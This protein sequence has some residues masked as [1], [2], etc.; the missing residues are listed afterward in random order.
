[1][2]SPSISCLGNQRSSARC[3]MQAVGAKQPG[4]PPM[5]DA[6]LSTPKAKQAHESPNGEASW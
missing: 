4:E 3:R 1:M 5:A 6:L 2:Y